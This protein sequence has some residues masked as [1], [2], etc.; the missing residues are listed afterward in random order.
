M[1]ACA[2]HSAESICQCRNNARA[3]GPCQGLTDRTLVYTADTPLNVKLRMDAYCGACA[4][5]KFTI[6]PSKTKVV[7]MKLFID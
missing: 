5:T 4:D 6:P 1:N 3:A 2:L 7:N